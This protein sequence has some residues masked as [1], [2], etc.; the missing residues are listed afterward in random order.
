MIKKLVPKSAHWLPTEA[1]RIKHL[2]RNQ[3]Y[4]HNDFESYNDWF[5]F[6]HLDPYTRMWHAFGM[7][8]GTSFYLL[9]VYEIIS[10][11]LTYPFGIYLLLGAF[12]FYFLPLISHY[13]YEGGG[14]K[15]DPDHLHST[16]IPV[17]HINFLTLTGRY[18]EW[19]RGFIKKYPFVH[20][21]W[22]LEER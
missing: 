2:E 16:F 3:K 8:I 18:D 20:E 21:A 19:L 5:Y 14:A 22:E 15:A 4:S 10:H 6:I 7:L 1:N 17:I 9:S 13:A 11:G 12:F